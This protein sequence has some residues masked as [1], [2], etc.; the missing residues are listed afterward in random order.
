[1]RQTAYKTWAIKSEEIVLFW[2]FYHK[3]NLQYDCCLKVNLSKLTHHKTIGNNNL[4]K[5]GVLNYSKKIVKLSPAFPASSRLKL[6]D[7]L[8]FKLCIILCIEYSALFRQRWSSKIL[9]V[10]EITLHVLT[11]D[12][13]PSR[14]VIELRSSTNQG[15]ELKPSIR[16]L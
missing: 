1:M 14:D 3:M 4:E 7:L 16:V 8:S 6:F 12:E 13:K 11:A 2:E 9:K 15:N 10:K 5:C